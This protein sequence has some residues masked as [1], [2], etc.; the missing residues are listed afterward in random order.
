MSPDPD[1]TFPPE[2]ELALMHM[3]ARV[4]PKMAAAFALDQRLGRIVAA[5]TEP[6]LGQM[7]L[8]W[9]RDMLGAPVGE[10]PEGD[11]VLDAIGNLWVGEEEALISLVNAWEVMVVADEL[12]PESLRE[13][14]QGRGA[15]WNSDHGQIWALADAAIRVS[16]DSE[17]ATLLEMAAHPMQPSQSGEPMPRGFRV[18]HALAKRALRRGGRPLMEGRG[19]SLIAMRA[20]LFGR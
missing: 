5:T 18:L 8:A 2:I 9:W 20:A 15:F 11:A 12:T 1:Q 16:D 4:R 7:R 14:A 6:M 19:A 13:Y 3:P 17:R 10:R